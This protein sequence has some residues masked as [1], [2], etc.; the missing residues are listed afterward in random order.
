I[1]RKSLGRHEIATIQATE[2]DKEAGFL[3]LTTVL[4]HSSGEWISSDWPVCQ[5]S[6]IASAQRMGA[7]LTY[8]RR[9]ALFTLVGIAGEDDLDAPDLNANPNPAASIPGSSD[10]RKQGDGPAAVAQSMAARNGR[11]SGSSARTVLGTQLSASLRES[12]IEQ[13]AAINSPDEAA[14]WAH[15]NLPAKNT[16]TAVDAK[17]VEDRFQA[18]LSTFID[19]LRDEEMAEEAQAPGETPYGLAFARPLHAIGGQAVAVGRGTAPK[20][21]NESSRHAKNQSNQNV[22]QALGKTV[23][24]RNKDHRN[25]VLRQPCLV[26]G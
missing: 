18:K 9:Y 22:I 1:V 16:L 10:H 12:L 19:I 21:D 26:C 24:L 15:R 20:A 25:F 4:A 17:I 6:D 3:R 5:I 8:A 7:A 2:I 14:V 11:P 23:R 13:L